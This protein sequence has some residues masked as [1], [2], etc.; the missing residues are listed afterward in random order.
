MG[1]IIPLQVSVG[2]IRKVVEQAT[3]GKPLS[4]IL[5]WSLPLLFL[6]GSY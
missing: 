2:C 3:R 1:D 4:S 5:L 6:L